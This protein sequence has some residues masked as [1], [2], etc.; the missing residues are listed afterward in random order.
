M[1]CDGYCGKI[2]RSHIVALHRNGFV[3][4]S[5]KSRVEQQDQLLTSLG[6]LVDPI[7]R[8]AFGQDDPAPM[9][10]YLR[11]Q[12]QEDLRQ[13]RPKVSAFVRTGKYV[14]DSEF[15]DIMGTIGAF[16]EILDMLK[17]PQGNKYAQFHFDYRLDAAQKAI[18]SVPCDDPDTIM[19]AES[20][21]QTYNLLRAICRGAKSRVQLFD[22]YLDAQ[23]F[24]RY[25]ME[26]T[27]NV[28]IT[29]VTSEAIMVVPSGPK[30]LRRD[31]IVSVSELFA[32]E[33]PTSYRFLVTP[34]QHDRHLR[35]DDAI[36]HL[37][38]S[39]KDAAVED[40]YTIAN[41]DPTQ[42]NHAFLDGMIN[43]STEWFGPNVTTHRRT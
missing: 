19:P 25:L 35:V 26:A 30:T 13:F 5:D 29:V 8:A 38:G 22:P 14:F 23:P 17:H 9:V 34:K 15:H 4:L 3:P 28:E 2:E 18:R 24:H 16:E 31:R 21:L 11:S 37:G 41:L 43:K 27:E 40:P 36:H 39:I 33:R 7:R 1:V 10:P 32:A 20:P 12:F 6:M 42:S